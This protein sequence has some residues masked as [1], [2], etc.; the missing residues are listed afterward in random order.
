MHNCETLPGAD[1]AVINPAKIYDYALNPDHPVG[2]NKAR[3]FDSALGFTLDN[4]DDLIGQLQDGLS[5]SEA[6]LGKLDQ[7]GQRCTVDIPVTGPAG[8][9]IVRTGW[10]LAPGAETPSMTTLFVK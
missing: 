1:D 6:T 10:I 7:Y 8:S 5:D 3:V 9:G 4:A 2:M